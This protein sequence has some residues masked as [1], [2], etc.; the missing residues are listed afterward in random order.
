MAELTYLEAYKKECLELFR[1]ESIH[2]LI[3]RF[4]REVKGMGWVGARGAYLVALSQ[5]FK[6]RCIPLD[7]TVFMDKALSL[8]RR[9]KLVDGAI[10]AID[11]ND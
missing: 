6:E 4:N 1:T 2:D 11:L 8:R 10:V 3:N 9:I 5:A 7:E